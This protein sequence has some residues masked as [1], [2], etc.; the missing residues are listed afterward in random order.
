MEGV[1]RPN[2]FWLWILSGPARPK[3]TAKTSLAVAPLLMSTCIASCQSSESAIACR[4]HLRL[5]MNP[6]K[7]GLQ[8]CAGVSWLIP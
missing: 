1:A 6:W 3:S 8:D 5:P 4:A 7:I 2:S